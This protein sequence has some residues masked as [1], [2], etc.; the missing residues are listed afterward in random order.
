[1]QATHRGSSML[2]FLHLESE[3]SV[4]NVAHLR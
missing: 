3:T 1:M 4:L 2:R